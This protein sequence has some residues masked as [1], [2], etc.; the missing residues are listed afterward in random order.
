MINA[1]PNIEISEMGEIN[2]AGWQ[3]KSMSSLISTL[4]ETDSERT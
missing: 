4:Q 3:A 1:M 2:R